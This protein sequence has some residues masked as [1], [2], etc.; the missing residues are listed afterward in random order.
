MGKFLGW[1]SALLI[2]FLAGF[3]LTEWLHLPFGNFIDWVIG[4]SI[5]VWLIIIVTVPWN[6]YFQSQ[7]VL[8]QAKISQERGINIDERQLPYVRSLAQ[9]S[10]GLAL[11]LHLVSAIALYVLASSGVGTI[12]YVGAI[13][14]LLLTILRPAISAYEY[15]SQRLR[16]ISQ[17]IDYPRE[18]VMELRQRFSSLEESFKRINEELNRESP[19]SLVSR[20]EQ[21]AEETR[22]NLAGLGANIEELRATNERDHERV[23]RESRQAIA[24]LS[25]DSQFLEHVREIIRFFK[26]A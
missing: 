24:Q 10:L 11:G 26:S 25:T 9:R 14:A 13:A 17:Q 1:L 7:S 2:I 16:S 8:N 19:Y 5:F 3:G 12:G 18:D 6:L 21:F 15:I 22:K 23:M 20:Y 4:A